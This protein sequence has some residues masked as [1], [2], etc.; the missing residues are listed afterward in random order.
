MGVL[1]LALGGGMFRTALE[2]HVLV[3]ATWAVPGKGGVEVRNRPHRVLLSL[4]VKDC[5]LA[6][7]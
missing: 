3:L 2:A 7:N 1:V 5:D 6:R 4:P